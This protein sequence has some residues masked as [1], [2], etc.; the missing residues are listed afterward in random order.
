MLDGEK[1]ADSD[2]GDGDSK[3]WQDASP[4]A[5]GA[6]AT[7]DDDDDYVRYTGSDSSYDDGDN[8]CD[9][10]VDNVVDVDGTDDVSNAGACYLVLDDDSNLAVEV[11][12]T[13]K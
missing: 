7:Y 12:F 1:N 13:H 10:D 3:W 11:K 2:G 5:A 4:T 8:Y 6:T 9:D